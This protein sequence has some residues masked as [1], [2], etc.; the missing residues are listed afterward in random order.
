MLAIGEVD[1]LSAHGHGRN[2]SEESVKSSPSLTSHPTRSY[3]SPPAFP[4]SPGH[5]AQCADLLSSSTERFSLFSLL[6]G[7][8]WNFELL[9]VAI[10]MKQVERLTT[11]HTDGGVHRLYW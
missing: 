5:P 8:E 11:H 7:H 2:E 1:P 9:L 4:W 10:E 3:L 6:K